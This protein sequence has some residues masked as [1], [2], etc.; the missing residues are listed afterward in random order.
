[1]IE[2]TKRGEARELPGILVAS[3]SFGTLHYDHFSMIV[4][5]VINLQYGVRDVG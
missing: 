5:V 1:M 2:F 4:D 3:S